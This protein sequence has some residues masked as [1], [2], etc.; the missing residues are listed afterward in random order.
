LIN[1][2][3]EPGDQVVVTNTQLG[4]YY[5]GDQTQNYF[6]FD[7]ENLPTDGGRIWFVEDNNLGEKTADKL[8][9][10]EANSELI[11]NFDVHVRAR[12]FKMRVYLL[13]PETQ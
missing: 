7:S 5:T 13:D 9:W 6:R 11:A 10:V 1:R 2:L 8:R 4:D 3:K 12:N